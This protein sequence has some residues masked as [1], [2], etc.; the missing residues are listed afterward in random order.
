MTSEPQ[1][2][3]LAEELAGRINGLSDAMRQTALAHGIEPHR[4][5]NFARD[6]RAYHEGAERQRKPGKDPRFNPPVG[7]VRSE[8]R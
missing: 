1:V 8:P 2:A 3:A 4:L 6:C 5:R 7:N